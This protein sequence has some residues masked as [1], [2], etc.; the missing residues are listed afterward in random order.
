MKSPY[1]PESLPI[2]ELDHKRLLPLVG[3]ARGALATYSGLL[4]GLANSRVLLAPLMSEEAVV[5][6]K[7]EGTQAT[8]YELF[9]YE[10]G[11]EQSE[12]KGRDIQE[13]QNYRTA[14]MDGESALGKYPFSLH[15]VRGLHE[16]LMD[17]VRGEDKSP[18]EFRKNQ[19]W[20]GKPGCAIE[21]ASFVPPSPLV[22][23]DCLRSW[24]SYAQSDDIDP[25]LQA[26]IVHAQ[27][28][29]IHPFKDGNGRIGRVIITLFLRY[30]GLLP[31]P[32]FYLSRYLERNREEYSARLSAI[33]EAGDW[34]GW[35]DFFLRAVRSQSDENAS[36]IRL[37]LELY[38]RTKKRIIEETR[39]R[40]AI[41][42]L[43]AIFRQPVFT[44]SMLVSGQGIEKPTVAQLVRKMKAAGMLTEI[45]ETR[46]QRPAV[47]CFPELLKITET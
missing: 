39:S 18:G 14:L 9:Q 10:A 36:K 3:D 31:G 23:A 30:K 7:I 29:L 15:L 26:A 44:A 22:L 37:I 34:D 41:T 6:S 25:V 24:E 17:S 1:I 35:L 8:Q 42:V 40:Y 11:M 46:G 12:E 16:T 13:I 43:D 47:L 20:I 21:E 28:E 19:N 5:S 32:Q 45:R 2:N 38:E 27:F 4:E 33:S